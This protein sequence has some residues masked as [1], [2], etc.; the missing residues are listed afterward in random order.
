LRIR[1]KYRIISDMAHVFLL[2]RVIAYSI[3]II[4]L[5]VMFIMYRI[6]RDR[7]I[8]WSVILMIPFTVLV[9]GEGMLAYMH[10]NS[11]TGTPV[12]LGFNLATLGVCLLIA[13][14]PLFSHAMVKTGNFTI[15]NWAFCCAA[16][17][18]YI[19]ELIGSTYPIANWL[20]SVQYGV[21]ITSIVYAIAYGTIIA[22]NPSYKSE[23]F[24]PI[25]KIATWVGYSMI[26]FL[27]LF[28]V[29]DFFY[30]YIPF[31][32]RNV[33][34][35][36]SVLPFFYVYWNVLLLIFHVR[37]ITPV[38]EN[39]SNRVAY[40]A[41]RYQLTERE[42]DVLRLLLEGEQYTSI[43]DILCIS[44][45]TVKTHVNHIYKKTGTNS[46]HRLLHLK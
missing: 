14:L 2:I 26:V 5:F 9:V 28:I 4:N 20:H 42:T 40:I 31:I 29:F 39:T 10:I 36:I 45:A 32:H 41:R 43:A 15:V 30:A 8:L 44:L 17:A 22:Q 34:S 18:I 25:A 38:H 7:F 27:P 21:L 1:L 37:S 46:R 13:V 19:I 24:A 11:I 12:V 33:P 3:G 6:Y 35:E 23:K 16:A